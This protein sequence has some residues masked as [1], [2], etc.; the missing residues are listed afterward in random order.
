[1]RWASALL[2]MPD[3]WRWRR[4][5]GWACGT[6]AMEAFHKIGQFFGIVMKD[7]M[8]D[9]Q[10]QSAA[11][12]LAGAL[13]TLGLAATKLI[14]RRVTGRRNSA[15]GSGGGAAPAPRGGT[16]PP[17]KTAPA[18]APLPPS[19]PK[20]A[21]A[22][23]AAKGTT[24]WFDDV[25]RAATRNPG[26][27]KLVLGHFAKEGVSYQKVASHYKA[28][29]FKVDD[30]ASVT[31]GLTQDEIWRINETFLTQQIKQGKQ[32]IFSLNPTTARAGSF[33]EKEVTFLKDL[34]YT[35]K[36]KDQW[37]WEAIR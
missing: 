12:L 29:Y 26:S 36:Q 32:V 21:I 9:S 8:T 19:Q 24:A 33:F 27:D 23:T 37:T 11:W 1:M 3:C 2:S 22:V 34:G 17:R 14:F 31:K 7:R 13:I 15:A 4:A 10:K 35:F 6:Q 25:A 5:F 16:M 18:A 20:A 28:T 30:W